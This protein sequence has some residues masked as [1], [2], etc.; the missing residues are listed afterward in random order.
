MHVNA[1]VLAGRCL[2][3]GGLNM[4]FSIMHSI[5]NLLVLNRLSLLYC[6]IKYT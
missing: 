4:S 2:V 3:H 6:K 5:G 1:Q